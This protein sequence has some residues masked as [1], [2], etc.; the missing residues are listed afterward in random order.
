MSERYT[1]FDFGL[2]GLAKLFHEDWGR[3]RAALEVVGDYARSYEGAA[4]RAILRDA[5]RLL[6]SDLPTWVVG[7]LWEAA[8]GRNHD[9]AHYGADGREWLRR[10]VD[11]CRACTSQ[12]DP[13]GESG[14]E[15]GELRALVLEEID[16]VAPALVA[17]TEH[18]DGDEVPGAVTALRM[19]VAQTDADLGF[20][21]FLRV[22]F[23]YPIPIGEERYARY[24][25]L[26]QRFG[27][28]EFHVD[29]VRFLTELDQD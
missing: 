17:V 19:C 1:E 27:Y 7:A 21:L 26:G 29:D 4:A 13:V 16:A 23:R 5:R 8:T 28:G 25:D 22:L 2:T 10:V 14:I 3:D 24:A 9:L 11:V 18:G 15:G 20:R 6:D 12:D